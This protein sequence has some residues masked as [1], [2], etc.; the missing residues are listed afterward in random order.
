MNKNNN[1]HDPLIYVPNGADI[2]TD[3]TKKDPPK[4]KYERRKMIIN[5]DALKEK[6]GVKKGE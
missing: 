2:N 4:T 5:R 3:C 6:L 1:F